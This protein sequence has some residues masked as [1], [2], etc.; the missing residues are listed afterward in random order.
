MTIF[1]TLQS[2]QLEITYTA[3]EQNVFYVVLSIAENQSLNKIMT[4]FYT[5]QYM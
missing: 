4:I 1:Y 5:L 3:Q 2:N